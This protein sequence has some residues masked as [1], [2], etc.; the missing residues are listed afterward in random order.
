MLYRAFDSITTVGVENVVFQDVV[1]C[2]AY[3]AVVLFGSLLIG[4]VFGLSAGLLSRFTSHISVIEPLIV[5][6]FGYLSFFSMEMFHLS[7]ILSYVTA[8]VVIFIIF[9]TSLS[10]YIERKCSWSRT[11]T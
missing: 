1:A 10:G 7:G 11:V 3:C 6:I 4:I 9:S 2:L 5:F 8:D